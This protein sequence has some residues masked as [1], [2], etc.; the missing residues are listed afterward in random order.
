MS[1]ERLLVWGN[2]VLISCFASTWVKVGLQIKGCCDYSFSSFFLP[3]VFP[4]QQGTFSAVM[5]TA[6]KLVHVEQKCFK[7]YK[8]KMPYPDR[9]SA[10]TAKWAR[11]ATQTAVPQLGWITYA[12]WCKYLIG[13]E[14]TYLDNFL[15]KPSLEENTFML[16][17][18]SDLRESIN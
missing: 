12:V 2:F 17:V 1:A 7:A 16:D 9:S 10:P 6:G 13:G 15:C 14:K 3:V 5:K 11:K 18:L 4:F 8:L